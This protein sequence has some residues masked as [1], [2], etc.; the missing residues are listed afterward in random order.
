[1]NLGYSTG[2]LAL[3]DF[4]KGIDMLKETN[5]TSIELSALREHEFL[6][7]I[8]SLD[9]LNLEGFA[10]VSFHAP[11]KLK[12][13]S[14]KEIINCLLKVAKR[15][16]PIVI[17]PDIITENEIEGWNEFGD[18][19][20]IENMD[21][22]KPI[23]RTSDDLEQIFDCFPNASFCLDMAHS[24]QI[25][26]TMLETKK[27]LTKF[28]DRLKQIHLSEV[29]SNCRHELLNMEAILSFRKVSN[30]IPVGIPVILESP[31]PFDIYSEFKMASLIFENKQIFKKSFEGVH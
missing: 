2:S 4:R 20:C 3:G 28:A 10:Y 18:L 13:I 5:A 19:L 23:G 14:E 17:H 29:N 6:D 12:D 8:A 30:L 1:M 9:K 25:D 21:K 31:K 16:W 26:P 24:K 11:S 15:N 22:R 27:M 7:I